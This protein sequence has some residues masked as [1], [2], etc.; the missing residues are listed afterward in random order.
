MTALKR[1]AL[2]LDV[3][4]TGAAVAIGVLGAW[5]GLENSSLWVDELFTRWVV[6]GDG[7]GD[8]LAARLMTDVHPPLYYALAFAY[9]QIT[10]ASDAALRALSAGLACA[11]IAV[12]ILGTGKTFSLPGRLFAAGV[13]TGS[14]FWFYQ[15]QNARDYSL[16]LL[17]GAVILSLSLSLLRP[18]DA[19]SRARWIGLATTMALGALTHVYVTF[20]S[21]AV[22]GVL[23][24]YLPKYR[25]ALAVGALMLVAFVL[26]YTTLI[27]GPHAQYSLTASW[28]KNSPAWD[29]AVLGSAVAMSVNRIAVPAVA[30]CAGVAVY[31]RVAAKNPTSLPWGAGLQGLKTRPSL[32]LCSLVPLLVVAEGVLGSL[33]VSPNLT[34]RNILVCSPFIWGLM[35][36]VF[37]AAFDQPT[38]RAASILR[39]GVAVLVLASA[40]IVLGRALPRNEPYKE[41][42]AWIKSLPACQGATIP[43][44]Q[45]DAKGWA[46]ADFMRRTTGY[47]YARY[48]DGYAQPKVLYLD[49]I[50]SGALPAILVSD[51]SA[52]LAGGGCPVLGW[53]AHSL[54][55]PQAEAA[56][57]ALATA[58][59]RGGQSTPTVR[60]KTFPIY[61]FSTTWRQNSPAGYVIYVERPRE[62]ALAH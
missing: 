44:I 16:S 6:T 30:V 25:G 50:V 29:K 62:P 26:A 11:A 58:A 48:L 15:S 31:R 56:G 4:L 19:K 34:D 47:G 8:T 36:L 20:M 32:V 45:T 22:L 46:Q 54:N 21:L 60:L 24:L 18:D 17:L 2:R 14:G 33:A 12:F 57:Q 37:D 7:A 39:L 13:A 61:G 41:A 28:I 1:P 27:I 43:V 42:A 53:G 52:R 3:A 23:F 35:A 55:E 40:S 38:S 51:L 9:G 10:G 5:V 59:G 49:D